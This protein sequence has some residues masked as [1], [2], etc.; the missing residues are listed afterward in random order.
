MTQDFAKQTRS[1]PDSVPS[2]N[3]W[4]IFLGGFISGVFVTFL[5]SI[6]YFAPADP[7]IRRAEPTPLT[8]PPVQT[9]EIQWGFYEIFPKAVVPVVEEYDSKGEKVVVAQFSWILQAGSFHNADDAD[10]RRAVLLLLG[11]DVTTSEIEVAGTHWHRV[12][13]GPYDTA[14]ALNRAQDE[15]A[16]AEIQS[17]AIKIPR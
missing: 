14:L 9:E 2:S 10:E 12:I 17:I 1:T 6:W 7:A 8:P 3:R 4:S 11:L 15:L 16:Q 5:A 13:A